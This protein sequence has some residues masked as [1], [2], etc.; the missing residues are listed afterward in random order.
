MRKNELLLK[1]V[2]NFSFE[3]QKP[4]LSISSLGD[5]QVCRVLNYPFRSIVYLA[6]QITSICSSPR[7]WNRK[8]LIFSKIRGEWVNAEKGTPPFQGYSVHPLLERFILRDFTI[9]TSF[10]ISWSISQLQ[11]SSLYH[12]IAQNFWVGLLKRYERI[13][14]KYEMTQ[15]FL[16]RETPSLSALSPF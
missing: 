3:T 16:R 10:C 1:I 11:K 12:F 6:Y 14:K 9:F 4:P 7:W 2:Y 8:K 5:D 13:G 15:P